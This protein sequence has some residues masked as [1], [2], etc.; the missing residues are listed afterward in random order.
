MNRHVSKDRPKWTVW[1]ALWV[2]GLLVAVGAGAATAHGL[3]EVAIGAGVPAAI[4]WLYPLITDGLALVAYGSTARLTGSAGRYAWAVVVLSAGLSGM[5]QASYLAGGVGTA[6]SGIRFGVGAW[7]AVA[8]AIV[9]HLL[10]LIGHHVRLDV[11]G[12]A[13]E[14][15]V[16]PERV[17]TAA[18]PPAVQPAVHAST[19][20]PALPASNRTTSSERTQET[21]AGVHRAPRREAP[22]QA[23]APARER[24]RVAARR[25]A[26]MHGD[27]PT[28]THLMALA[29]VARGT[30][31]NALKELREQPAQLHVVNDNHD[32]RTDQ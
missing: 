28:V 3:Y 16:H 29:D 12:R 1:L 5:A 9:A 25:H 2:P 21:A 23:S 13:P 11:H 14:A 18:Q 19:E 30:A 17:N 6:T 4:A 20:H 7:P 31:G 26:T 15:S 22:S 10:F 24:A 8:A 27:L 32:L